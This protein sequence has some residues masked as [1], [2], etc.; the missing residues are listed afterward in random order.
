[1]K[2]LIVCA[3]GNEQFEFAQSIGIGIVN[4]AFNLGKILSQQKVDKII[5]IG[6]CGIYQD[7]N[8]F[9]IY[10]STNACN[11][12]YAYF[13]ET[14]YTPINNTIN[15]NVSCE[16][17]IVNSSNYI[18][19]DKNIAKKYAQ[20]GIKIE[21]MEAYSILT[22]AKNFGIDAV[23]YL[24]ATNFCDENAH[25]YFINNHNKAKEKLISFLSDKKLI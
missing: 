10:E 3:G 11:I 1:M 23:C 21:N 19:S 17:T 14:F 18:C 20:L 6:T 22:C 12:E 7:G 15:L 2:N 9:D 5:F 13:F 8:I 16:T 4:S 24:C 25:K